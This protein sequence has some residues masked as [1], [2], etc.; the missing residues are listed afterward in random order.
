MYTRK[1]T[2]AQTD[3][4][5]HRQTL[6]QTDSALSLATREH[7][8]MTP[9]SVSEIGVDLNLIHGYHANIHVM[10]AYGHTVTS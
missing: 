4:H 5:S 6:W 10:Q 7:T 2:D 1:Q 3:R 8:L 9:M